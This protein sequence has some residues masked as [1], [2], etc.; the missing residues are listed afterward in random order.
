MPLMPANPTIIIAHVEGSGT[1]ATCSPGVMKKL[2][3]PS[4]VLVM[5]IKNAY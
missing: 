3:G 5:R 1:A 2:S 4:L